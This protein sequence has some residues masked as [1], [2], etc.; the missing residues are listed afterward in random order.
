MEPCKRFICCPFV[1]YP[2]KLN[3]P[4]VQKWRIMNILLTYIGYICK[5]REAPYRAADG[6]PEILN[7]GIKYRIIIR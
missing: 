5:N 6:G 1:V 2:H 3:I 7:D 4:F